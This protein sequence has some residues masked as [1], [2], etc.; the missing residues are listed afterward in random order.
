MT[1]VII[2]ATGTILKH[3]EK[4][5]SNIPLKNGVEELQKEKNTQKNSHVWHCTHTS[6]STNV[7]IQNI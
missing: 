5:L 1:P 4:D 2:G 7:K 3:S 6:E